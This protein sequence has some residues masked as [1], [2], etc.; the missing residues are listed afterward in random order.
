MF[1]LEVDRVMSGGDTRFAS[2]P[3]PA[4]L[5]ATKADDVVTLLRPALAGPADVTI[6]GDISVCLLYTSR[7]V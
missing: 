4:D 3:A 5:S 6:V 1:N 2:L 7:C